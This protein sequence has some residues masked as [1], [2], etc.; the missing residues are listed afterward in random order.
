MSSINI[1]ED[2][3]N[4][5]KDDRNYNIKIEISWYGVTIYLDFDPSKNFDEK[6]IIPIY[7]NTLEEWS[8]IPITKLKKMY[9]PFENDEFVG[10]SFDDIKII[11]Q[12]MEYFENHKKEINELCQRFDLEFRLG[13]NNGD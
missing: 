10:I 8:C 5:F 4:M 9:M 13:E 12:I 2:V 11:Y 3:L 6:M 7:Y 1:V